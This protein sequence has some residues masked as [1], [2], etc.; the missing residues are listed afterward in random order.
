MQNRIKKA[1]ARWAAQSTAEH[2]QGG[3]L[4][5]LAGIT[6][7]LAFDPAHIMACSLAAAFLHEAGHAVLYWKMAGRFPKLRADGTGFSLSVQGTAFSRKQETLLLL[8]GPFTNF[9]LA[10]ATIFLLWHRQ[11]YLGWFFATANLLMGAFNLLPVGCLDGGRLLDCLLPAYL[12]APRQSITSFLGLF[13]GMLLAAAA[14]C[15]KLSLSA[16][17]ALAVVLCCGLRGG[18]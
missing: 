11:S 10:L 12:W 7:L 4:F 9:L 1:L 18:E 14:L 17:C 13:A 15:G 6:V 8:A 2:S 16:V 5:T 3:F